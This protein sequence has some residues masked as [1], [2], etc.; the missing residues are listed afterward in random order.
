MKVLKI[1]GLI[2]GL[3]M[4]GVIFL[5]IFNKKFEYSSSVT[6]NALPEKSWEVF[7]IPPK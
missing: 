5:G 1:I 4:V 6:V 7:T 3:L 2:V